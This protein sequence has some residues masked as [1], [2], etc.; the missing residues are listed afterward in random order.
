MHFLVSHTNIYS[1]QFYHSL[2]SFPTGVNFILTNVFTYLNCILRLL[3]S[4]LSKLTHNLKYFFILYK[5]SVLS[6]TISASL[7][8]LYPLITP[9]TTLSKGGKSTARASW[10]AGCALT[11]PCSGSDLITGNYKDYTRGREREKEIE[12]KIES[13]RSSLCVLNEKQHNNPGFFSHIIPMLQ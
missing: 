3:W 10:A 13:R 2:S 8:V 11:R 7:S 6:C 4:L 1:L 5:H 12:I 9:S